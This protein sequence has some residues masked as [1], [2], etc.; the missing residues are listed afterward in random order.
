VGVE[1]G[2]NARAELAMDL[3]LVGV[4]VEG[5]ETDGTAAVVATDT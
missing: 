5:R 1:V 3:A 2:V 4:T